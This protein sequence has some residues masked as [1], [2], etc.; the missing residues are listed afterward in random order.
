MVLCDPPHTT[1]GMTER[2]KVGGATVSPFC[3][4]RAQLVSALA[5]ASTV[6]ILINAPFT[7]LSI[8]YHIMLATVPG[9]AT[10]SLVNSALSVAS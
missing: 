10:D 9:R 6:M 8:G 1:A 3:S 2:G 7:R 5:M 4:G